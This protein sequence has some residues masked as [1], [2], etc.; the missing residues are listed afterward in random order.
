MNR[1][2]NLHFVPTLSLLGVALAG[3]PTSAGTGTLTIGVSGEEA[4]T[5]G[6]P[7]GDI[8]FRDG[9]T[10]Q[11]DHIFAAVGDV[12]LEEGDVEFVVDETIRVVDLAEAAELTYGTVTGVPAQRWSNFVYHLSVPTAS[13]PRVGRVTAE[14]VSQ[15]VASGSTLRMVGSA[16]HPTHGVYTFDVSIPAEVHMSGCESG[17]DGTAGIVVPTNA[18]YETQLTLHLDH[19]F[20]DS[21]RAEEPN[22]RFEA[23]AAVAGADRNV[24]YAELANQSLADLRGIDGMPLMDGATPVVYEPPATGLPMQN[25]QAFLLDQALTIGHFEGEGHCDYAQH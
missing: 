20:F 18:I 19:F 7:A 4:A 14:D 10:M 17:R 24:T 3:C 5:G 25:L 15:M 11:F 2:K 23:W 9:W 6:Y 16:T 13:S 22:L 1:S 8:A 12:A 21:A